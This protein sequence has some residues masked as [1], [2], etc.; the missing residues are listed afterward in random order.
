MEKYREIR[1]I[2]LIYIYIYLYIIKIYESSIP[3]L[4]FT[5]ILLGVIFPQGN[6]AT[7]LEPCYPTAF[8]LAE[9]S[10]P[11]SGPREFITSSCRPNS[12]GIKEI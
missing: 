5:L 3:I 7:L 11:L 4:Y 9:T 1:P 2:I 10:I 12:G 6:H 8:F